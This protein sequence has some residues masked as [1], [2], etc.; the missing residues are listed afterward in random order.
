M[1]SYRRRNASILPLIILVVLSSCRD[2]AE[3]TRAFYYWRTDV[4]EPEERKL[5]NNAPSLWAWWR[6]NHS[7]Q[8]IPGLHENNIAISFTKMFPLIKK[9]HYQNRRI[10]TNRVFNIKNLPVV[11]SQL[12]TNSTVGMFH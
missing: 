10:E 5:F 8:K 6:R 9:S 12:H 3:V 7:H 4:P 1:D 2:R 11:F